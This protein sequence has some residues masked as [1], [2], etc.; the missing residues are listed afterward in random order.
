MTTSLIENIKSQGIMTQSLDPTILSS[1][2]SKNLINT[3]QQENMVKQQAMQI[4]QYNGIFHFYFIFIFFHSTFVDFIFYKLIKIL[5]LEQPSQIPLGGPLA[6]ASK[7]VPV[8]ESLMSPDVCPSVVQRIGNNCGTQHNMSNSL[9]G[10]S[11]RKG[12]LF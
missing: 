1:P 2:N 6:A 9:I 10:K 12:F 11:G 3:V 4:S 5:F 7:M 8:P